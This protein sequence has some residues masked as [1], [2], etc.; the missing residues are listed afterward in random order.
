M[1]KSQKKL[2]LKVFFLMEEQCRQKGLYVDENI[3]SLSL[4]LSKT[5]LEKQYT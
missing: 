3:Y 1:K 4:N 5:V 2:E